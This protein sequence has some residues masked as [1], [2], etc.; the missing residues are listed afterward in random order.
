MISRQD[1]QEIERM[2]EVKIQREVDRRVGEALKKMGLAPGFNIQDVISARMKDTRH[3]AD[4]HN[5]NG[6]LVSKLAP[7]SVL[8]K[9][10]TPGQTPTV[11]AAGT[12]VEW[13]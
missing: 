7:A 2:V 6:L 10:G 12:A 1:M 8:G 9:I 4:D 5:D 13:A 11:N 3:E